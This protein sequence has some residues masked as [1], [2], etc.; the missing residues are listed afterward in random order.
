M[1]N[2][3]EELR[4]STVSAE[5]VGLL[6]SLRLPFRV[7][8]ADLQDQKRRLIL[9]DSDSGESEPEPE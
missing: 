2:H 6:P 8:T 4:N 7:K 9:T 1:F 5:Y 3:S